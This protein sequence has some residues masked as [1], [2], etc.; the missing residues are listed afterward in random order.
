MERSDERISSELDLS[1]RW[2]FTTSW[3]A[4][5]GTPRSAAALRCAA[6]AARAT[7]RRQVDAVL[8]ELERF[9][10]DTLMKTKDAVE[11]IAAFLEKRQPVWSDA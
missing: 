3:L 5:A 2:L 10:L 1:R 11:G 8:P 4:T 6:W 7:T 9:Y